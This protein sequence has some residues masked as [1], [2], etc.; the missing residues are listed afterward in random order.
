MGYDMTTTSVRRIVESFIARIVI[1]RDRVGISAGDH[2]WLRIYGRYNR[3]DLNQI[4]EIK[5]R[6]GRILDTRQSDLKDGEICRVRFSNLRT[7]HLP[8]KPYDECPEL[9]R[10]AFFLYSVVGV[11]TDDV[12]ATGVVESVEY[13]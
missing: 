8:L 2:I 3:C 4:L 1:N 12:V 10:I 7:S 11:Y 5:D 6:S 13:L 9:S